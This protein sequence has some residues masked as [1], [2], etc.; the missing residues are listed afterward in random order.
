MY[1]ALA[2]RVRG[3]NSASGA[4]LTPPPPVGAPLMG[5]LHIAPTVDAALVQVD[6]SRHLMDATCILC[7]QRLV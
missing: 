1:V 5:A 6:W 2:R 3:F 4:E 7:I